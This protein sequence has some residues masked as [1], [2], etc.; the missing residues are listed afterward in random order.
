MSFLVVSMDFDCNFFPLF[1]GRSGDVM[2]FH[3]L[4]SLTIQ[5][6]GTDGPNFSPMNIQAQQMEELDRLRK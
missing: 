3:D 1:R 6:G 2:V 4:G 5:T